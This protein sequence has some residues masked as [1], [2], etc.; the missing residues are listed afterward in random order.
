MTGLT[1]P[2]R[3][4]ILAVQFL[5][6]IPTP[7]IRD[8]HEDDIGRSAPWFPAVGLLVGAAVA[9]PVELLSD[10]PQLAALAGLVVWVWITGALHIDGL[11][12]VADALGASHRDPAR[13]AAALKDPHMGAFG[14]VTVV[15]QLIAKFVLLSEAAHQDLT[16]VLVLVPA[17]ARWISLAL[18]RLTT[19]LQ[20]GLGERFGGQITWPT[21]AVWAVALSVAS[22][23]TSPV[24]LVAIP[25]AGAVALYW[26]RRLGG[27]SGD[28]LGASTEIA[29]SLLL[30]ALIAPTLS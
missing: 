19:S 1:R 6:R 21:V 5:T 8:F 28:G 27:V 7:Q 30:I 26:H 9:V 4:L 16:W 14:V 12:D 29:E 15:L 10:R 11:G 25:L 3:G 13:Y 24:L 20:A 22:V 2:L 18:P 23:L 17:W